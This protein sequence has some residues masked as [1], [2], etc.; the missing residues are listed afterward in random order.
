MSEARSTILILILLSFVFGCAG[1]IKDHS[2]EIDK[3]PE[4]TVVIDNEK[5]FQTY[6][7]KGREYENEGNLR[8]AYEQYKLALTVKPDDLT[9]QLK[10]TQ[11]EKTLLAGAEEHY[12]L[13][14]AYQKE[15][16]Y[17]LAKSEFLSALRLW[18]EHMEAKQMLTPHESVKVEKY[19]T[20]IIKP[21][22]SIS[23]LAIIY[24]GDYKKFPIIAKYNNLDDATQVEPG[25][26]IK[27]PIIEGTS[28]LERK[29]ASETVK[30]RPSLQVTS[31]EEIKKEI[32]APAPIQSP[33]DEEAKNVVETPAPMQSPPEEKIKKV[34]EAPVSIETYQ[35]EDTVEEK[36]EIDDELQ[37]ASVDPGVNYRELGIE[38]YRKKQYRDAIAEFVKVVN[39]NPGDEIAIKH[40]SLSHFHCAII[41]LDKKEYMSAKEEFEAALRYDEDCQK[42]SEYMK[43]SMDKYKKIHYDKGISYFGNE[44]LAEAIME[45]KLVHKI[46]P[47]YRKV[48]SNLIKAKT[49]Q[50]RLEQIKKSKQ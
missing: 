22:E 35:E 47:N 37:V 23:E 28:L 17:G 40:L 32:E 49:L 29:Q 15:G 4:E 16:R 18:P 8:D 13:G 45:W 21:G 50:E 38:L 6:L 34:V 3:P 41:L 24:Y 11:G 48:D 27:I 26:E 39:V 46:D 12:Q 43:T 9:A 19:I 14:L 33:P 10:I 2:P 25:E 36:E 42:C 7:A 5:L 44:Q 31:D 1:L 20:H 30:P